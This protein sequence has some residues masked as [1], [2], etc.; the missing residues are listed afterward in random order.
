MRRLCIVLL[1]HDARSQLVIEFFRCIE[2]V[3]PVPACVSAFWGGGGG[4]GGQRVPFS[5]FMLHRINS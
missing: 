1:F 2:T 3:L 5:F 4:G